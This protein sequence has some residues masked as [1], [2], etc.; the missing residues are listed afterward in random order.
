MTAKLKNLQR[1]EITILLLRIYYISAYY[2]PTTVI[3]Y[4][5]LLCYLILTTSYKENTT[6]IPI[7]QQKKQKLKKIR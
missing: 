7:F 6:I 4:L 3:R 2:V 1:K 5:Y